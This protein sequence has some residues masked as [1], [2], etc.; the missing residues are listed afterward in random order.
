MK[1][2]DK[3]LQELKK[4]NKTTPMLCRAIPEVTNEFKMMREIAKL[5]HS[6][7]VDLKSFDRIYREDGGA[8]YLAKYGI[9]K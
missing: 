8:I 7:E 2:K 3:I 1:L 4:G 9:K 5:Q 6:G